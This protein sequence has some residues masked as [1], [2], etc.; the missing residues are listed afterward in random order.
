MEEKTKEFI[1][2]KETEEEQ[3]LITQDKAGN[4][5]ILNTKLKDSFGKTVFSNNELCAQFLRRY[6]KIP[7]LKNVQA[8]DIEDVS[9]RFV[10]MFTEE[11]DADVIK[12]IKVK[13]DE[14]P[15]YLISLIEHKSNVEYNVV[16]QILRYIVF[17]WEDYEKKEN[18]KNKGISKTKDFKYPPVLPIIYYDGI[19][20]WTAALRLQERIYMN[21]LFTEYIPD[22]KCMLFS[23]QKYSNQEIADGKDELSILMLLDRLKD[24]SDFKKLNEE[25]PEGFFEEI[26]ENTPQSIMDIMF[27][28]IRVLLSKFRLSE[29]EI[30]DFIRKIKEVKSVGGWF[31]HFEAI[32]IPEEREKLREEREKFGK[33]REELDREK[34]ELNKGKEELNKGKEELN[35]GKEE[36]NKGKEELNKGKE[37]L[38]K[39]KEELNKAKKELQ[40]KE[41]EIYINAFKEMDVPK[42]KVA[43]RV[44]IRFSLSLEKAESKVEQYW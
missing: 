28:V 19:R 15:F 40:E 35:K 20:N 16:M 41:V 42:E 18:A 43:E 37:E 24:M 3:N 21:H 5:G 23:I 39:G 27:C 14:M 10:H 26:T 6:T 2:E 1:L 22:Y 12:K 9:N 38:N 32:N 25:L 29:E 4:E 8:E 34:E 17:I 7:Q 30:D 44:V 31:E 13:N 11:R 33:E 36:L